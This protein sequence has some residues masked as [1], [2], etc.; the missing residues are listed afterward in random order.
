MGIHLPIPRF[1]AGRPAYHA[2]PFLVASLSFAKTNAVA[3][4][5]GTLGRG[6]DPRSRLTLDE[7]A[8]VAQPVRAKAKNDCC[9]PL[10]S[11]F[12]TLGATNFSCAVVLLD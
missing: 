7:P 5:I 6:F 1:S 2:R 11:S 8:E 12:L 10:S 3:V 9:D 4:Y